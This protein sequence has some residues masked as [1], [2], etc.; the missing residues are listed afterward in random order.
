MALETA[1]FV[2]QLNPSYPAGSDRLKQGDDHIRLLK[3]ALQAT[4][5]NIKGQVDVS[6]DFLNALKSQLIPVGTITLFSGAAAPSGWGICDGTSY[7]KADGSGTLVSPDL[8]GRVAIG[9]SADNALLSL[10]GQNER[11]VTSEVAGAH[12]H[13]AS[14]AEAGAHTHTVSGSVGSS[15]AGV[16]AT[17]STRSVD[18]GSSATNLVT[19]V[20]IND[21]G[22]SHTLDAST[23]QA[24]AHTH[25][26][27]VEQAAAHSHSVKVDVRQ[28]SIALHYIIKL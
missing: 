3:A 1:Q 26:I 14:A 10:A 5:P 13:T 18:G 23:A 28:P 4:F 22:H 25:G 16:T 2:H 21:P 7:A 17:T 20:T 15:K 24:G 27:T 8:R 11:T 12:T 19:G 6:H 9:V